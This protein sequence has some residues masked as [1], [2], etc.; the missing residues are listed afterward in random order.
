M[1][2]IELV[3]GYECN[4]NCV[5]CAT[6]PVVLGQKMSFEEATLH[7]RRSR[8]EGATAVDFGGGEPTIRSDLPALV[9]TSV[10][11]GYTSTSVIS[12]GMLFCY[13]DFSRKLVSAGVNRFELSLWGPSQ[14]IHDSLSQIEGSFDRMEMGVKHLIDLGA[15]VEISVLL[16]N[17]T[18]PYLSEIVNDF[19]KIGARRFLLMLFCLFGSNYAT[20]KLYPELTAAGESVVEA[21]RKK[22]FA[23]TRIRTSHIPPCFMNG[24][25]G[26][27]FDIKEEEL[28]VI[29]PGNSFMVVQSPSES[30]TKTTRCIGCRL[31]NRCAGVRNEYIERF[32]DIEIKPLKAKKGTSSKVGRHLKK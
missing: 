17:E 14:D 32:T 27:Y 5:F 9:E 16:T 30:S 23:E 4:C 22:M 21:A 15:N 2:K 24:I 26:I 28:L 8:E 11:M 18:V 13:P 29:T 6:D 25:E 12:N 10:A 20:P 3:L 19:E 7:L 31:Y 1:K